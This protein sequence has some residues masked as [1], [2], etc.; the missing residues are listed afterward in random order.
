M[1]VFIHFS[2]SFHQF[3]SWWKP[4]WSN[5]VHLA[6]FCH[7]YVN[8]SI[9][10]KSVATKHELQPHHDCMLI[11]VYM[12]T[13]YCVYGSQLTKLCKSSLWLPQWSHLWNVVSSWHVH[14]LSSLLSQLQHDGFVIP[15]SSS[16]HTPSPPQV[17]NDQWAHQALHH[18]LLQTERVLWAGPFQCDSLW[19]EHASLLGLWWE[20]YSLW[21]S[22]ALSSTWRQWRAVLS[23]QKGVHSWGYEKAG[24]WAHSRVLCGQHPCQ[25]G[26][27]CVYWLLQRKGCRVWSQG[28]LAKC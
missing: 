2:I 22:Q 14:S 25:N 13:V 16:F 6:S 26:W 3:C 23:T 15:S 21:P 19:A 11:H 4:L 7:C 5:A 27:P 18:R 17:H 1:P 20:D 10:L 8:C 28:T 12:C 24:H 9:Y